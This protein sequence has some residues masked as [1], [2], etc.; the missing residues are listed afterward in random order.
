MQHINDLMNEAGQALL[1]RDYLTTESLCV[2]AL[3]EARDSQLWDHYASILMPLQEA[4]RQRRIIAAEGWLLIGTEDRQAL[5]DALSEQG[6]PPGPKPFT[7]P[8]KEPGVIVAAQIVITAPLTAE[9]ARWIAENCQ[10]RRLFVELLLAQGSGP[11]RVIRSWK[12]KDLTTTIPAPPK[13]LPLDTWISPDH[14]LH[15]DGSA[16]FQAA[17][18]ALGDAALTAALPTEPPSADQIDQIA[19]SVDAVPDH[20]LLHQRLADTAWQLQRTSRTS[21]TDTVP[22]T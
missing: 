14:K 16:W 3:A 22:V 15:T 11:N 8:G 5:L 7:S 1:D 4:R 10:L 17:S 18:E 20:E 13:D 6:P 2:Q 19:Q 12:Q 21:D 9:D